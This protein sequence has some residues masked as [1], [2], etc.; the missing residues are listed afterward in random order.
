MITL[1]AFILAI[2]AA[3][4]FFYL[5]LE[6]VGALFSVL[7]AILIGAIVFGIAQRVI[8]EIPK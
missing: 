3:V 7:I 5:L 1:I 8:R 2:L 4:G 6:L